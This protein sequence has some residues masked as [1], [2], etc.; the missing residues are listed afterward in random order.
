VIT[1]EEKLYTILT[2]GTGQHMLDSGGAY[3][4]HWQRN[5]LR[6]LESFKEEEVATLDE[7]GS[8]TIPLF[9]HLWEALNVTSLSE[10]LDADFQAFSKDRE[11]SYMED[12]EAFI[13]HIGA[14]A[15]Y[16]ENS[17]NRDSCLSQVIQYQTFAL[18]NRDYVAL[19]IHQG[20][21]VRGGYTRPYI[22]ELADEYALEYESGSIWC[23]GEEAHRY[24]WSGGEWTIEGSY[25]PAIDPYQLQTE[26]RKVGITEYIPCYECGAPLKGTDTRKEVNA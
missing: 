21:D 17:Y 23:E 13:K 19:Q 9:H 2:T 24:D 4:R 3:G 5:Q 12:S 26:A 1:V 6:S 10:A 11:G 22:F 25:N 14:E 16:S 18:G 15:G 8:L 7:W 20:A